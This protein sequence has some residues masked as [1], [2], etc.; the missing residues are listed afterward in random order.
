MNSE[1]SKVESESEEVDLQYIFIVKNDEEKFILKGSKSKKAFEKNL[2]KMD[3]Y[4][5]FP[6]INS[7]SDRAILY[8]K[9]YNTYGVKE[10]TDIN[11]MRILTNKFY[12]DR[13]QKF[14]QILEENKLYND[15]LKREE[16]T[17]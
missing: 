3:I 10:F 5:V 12:Q 14:K 13:Y 9:Y 1:E 7:E 8:T 17:Y 4:G 6:T 16:E 11:P 2:K 15:Y